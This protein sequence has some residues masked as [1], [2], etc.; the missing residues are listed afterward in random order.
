MEKAWLQKD[1]SGFELTNYIL[2]NLK[3]YSLTAAEALLFLYLTTFYNAQRRL[4]NPKIET[5]EKNLDIGRATVFRGIK[6]LCE[7]GYI[8]R[9]KTGK[10]SSYIITSAILVDDTQIGLKMIPVENVKSQ[11]DTQIGLKMI[12]EK[13]SGKIDREQENIQKN[14]GE[15]IIGTESNEED[16]SSSCKIGVFDKVR[17]WGVFEGLVNLIENEDLSLLVEFV[18]SKKPDNKGSY[19]AAV[20]KNNYTAVL[21]K[22][23]QDKEQTAQKKEAQE[24]HDK[25]AYEQ[26][27]ARESG[28][29]NDPYAD[30]TEEMAKTHYD[31]V[32][33]YMPPHRFEFNQMIKNLVSRFPNIATPF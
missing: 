17:S 31:N 12:P 4:I 2:T 3:H 30:W 26:F 7:R 13:N 24:E 15:Q 25:Q 14:E 11:N 22:L 16:K 32:K 8:Q 21:E 29:D 9:I 27:Q 10:K 33:R 18:E 5:I 28:K 1:F 6:K 20:L 23:K 19:L